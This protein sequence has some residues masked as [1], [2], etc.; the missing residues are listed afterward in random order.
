MGR[1]WS[2]FVLFGLLVYFSQTGLAQQ[3]QIKLDG[4][5]SEN[6]FLLTECMAVLVDEEE[7]IEVQILM[8]VE[9]RPEGY[10][11]I[12]LKKGDE[13]LMMNA[14]RVRKV[15]DLKEIYEGLEP[16][17]PVKL[18]IQRDM[19]MF[20]VTFKKVDPKKLPKREMKMIREGKGMGPGGAVRLANFGGVLAVKE[21]NGKVSVHKIFPGLKNVLDEG[22]LQEGDVILT[23]N[24]THVQSNK[25]FADVYT[26]VDVGGEVRLTISREG[27]QKN[28]K[29]NKPEPAE[30]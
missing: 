15:K 2:I 7:T 24:G 27:K 17:E 28:V 29:F 9:H 13:I 14:K 22:A 1:R 6:I 18:G 30:R 25:Q 26:K 19:E 3:F 16:G 8:P 4:K 11:E 23:V 5:S 12:D 21:M 20:I 10:A